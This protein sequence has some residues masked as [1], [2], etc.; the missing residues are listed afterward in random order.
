VLLNSLFPKRPVQ[1]RIETQVPLDGDVGREPDA[2]IR[3]R[4]PEEDGRAAQ[5]HSLVSTIPSLFASRH[6]YGVMK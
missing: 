6:V 2:V 1:Q 4:L 5:R 3:E